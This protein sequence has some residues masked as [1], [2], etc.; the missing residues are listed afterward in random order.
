MTPP[1]ARIPLWFGLLIFLASLGV[2]SWYAIEAMVVRQG[3]SEG[4]TIA[5]FAESVGKWA[6]QYGGVHVR[7]I[8]IESRMPGTFLTRATYAVSGSDASVLQGSRVGANIDERAALARVEAYHWKNPALVQREMADVIAASGSRA[9][10]RLT[11]T[12]VLN[13]SN[14]PNALEQDAMEVLTR[15]GVKEYWRVVG[16]ELFYA[17]AV[18]AQAS[19]LKCH[20]KKENAPEYISANHQFNGGGGFGYVAGK[21]AGLISVSLP[22]ARPWQAEPEQLSMKVW[23]PLFVAGLALVW[24]LWR[25]FRRQA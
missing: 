11:A 4:R 2:G 23:L 5:D 12:T 9:R 14:A 19:C 17:R 8:G 18:V 22:L 24:L 3:I 10:Y 25:A 20:D 13:P 7:T 16:K 1:R 21:P 15:T 6:S